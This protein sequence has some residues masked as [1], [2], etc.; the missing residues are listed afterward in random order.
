LFERAITTPL[1]IYFS[2]F[3]SSIG[4]IASICSES[5]EPTGNWV[6]QAGPTLGNWVSQ[7]G[8][9]FCL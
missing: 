3:F 5:S 1:A 8:P 9:T 7:A 4:R 6:S 2:L